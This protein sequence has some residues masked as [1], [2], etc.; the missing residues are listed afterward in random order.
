M[1]VKATPDRVRKTNTSSVNVSKREELVA[2][3]PNPN[4]R[5]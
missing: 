4:R 5:L 2:L 3:L 1:A